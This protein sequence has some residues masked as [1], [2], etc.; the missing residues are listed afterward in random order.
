MRG[1]CQKKKFIMYNFVDGKIDVD[2]FLPFYFRAKPAPANN[3]RMT[4]F[5]V[6]DGDAVGDQV[7]Y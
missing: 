6:D 5:D 2:T 1:E 7:Y 4:S 3:V